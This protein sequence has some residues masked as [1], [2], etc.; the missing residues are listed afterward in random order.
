[1]NEWVNPLN[2]SNYFP[3]ISCL[4]CISTDILLDD[5]DNKLTGTTEAWRGGWHSRFVQCL[6]S[7]IMYMEGL[8]A[9]VQVMIEEKRNKA[10]IHWGFKIGHWTRRINRWILLWV[11][12]RITQIAGAVGHRDLG[13]F[14]RK[15]QQLRKAVLQRKGT[16][17]HMQTQTHRN[18]DEV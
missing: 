11:I 12:R 1:M 16:H 15:L 10:L 6:S 3:F 4:P 13:D 9:S 8:D 18:P 14:C 17:P 7:H 2:K 5:Q